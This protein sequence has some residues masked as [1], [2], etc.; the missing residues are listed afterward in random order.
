MGILA[1]A[2]FVVRSTYHT[3]KC[4]SPCQLVF[5]R[6]IILP[7]NH[8]EDWRYIRQHKHTQIDND[9]IQKNA[10]RTNY[11]YRVGDKVT[12][13]TK[14]DYKYKTP[15]KGPYKIVQTWTN[16]TATL[17]MGAV[18]TIVNIC[19]IKRYNTL[20]VEG[21]YPTREVYTYI[22]HQHIY[23]YIIIHEP[24]YIH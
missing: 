8:L 4:K 14:S 15:F 12:T 17:I 13:L 9:V 23:M 2:A 3:N 16:G 18:T 5:G 20:I 11:N 10:T 22:F 24:I 6:D 19:N 7:I 21:Q 1:T